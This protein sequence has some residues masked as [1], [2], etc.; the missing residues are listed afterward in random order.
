[1]GT[2]KH[3]AA[4][5]DAGGRRLYMTE[6]DG[7]AGFY[8]F[9]PARYPDLSSGRLEVAQVRGNG[10]VRWLPV[11]DPSAASGRTIAQVPEATRFRRGEGIWFDRGVVYMAT[12]SDDRVWAY[13]ARSGEIEILYDG[14]ALGE[15]APLHDTDNLTICERSGDMFVCEDADDLDVCIV[16]PEGVV[17]RFAQLSGSAHEGSELTGPVF[18]PSGGRLFFA[19]QRAFGL[20][21]VY[22][23]SGPFRSRRPN[24]DR[25][26]L[27]VSVLG[28]PNAADLPRAGIP[29]R[30]QLRE[31]VAA[32]P[33]VGARLLADIGDS[34]P[35][36]V[37]FGERRLP[38]GRRRARLQLSPRP[39]AGR[40]A[41]G[42]VLRLVVTVRF[43]SGR[44]NRVE[45]PVRI[46]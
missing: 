25:V 46:D 33:Q 31:G 15:E 37:A 22:E 10:L 3:E 12:T 7:E 42:S 5:V 26:G 23:I 14:V 38:A 19:S 6:D 30:V 32:P 21:A 1:M 4:C 39:A 29:I 17:A 45:A 8:R 20:G 13:D 35:V 36:E 18:D 11:P 44:R 28:K 9:T 41:A 27:R 24:L 16:T 43:G 2:F 34:G 40:V